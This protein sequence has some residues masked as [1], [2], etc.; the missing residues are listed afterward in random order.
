MSKI[1]ETK[2]QKPDFRTVFSLAERFQLQM[3][4]RN[5]LKG[6]ILTVDLGETLR[7]KILVTAEDMTRLEIVSTVDGIGWPEASEARGIKRL[8]IEPSELAVIEKCLRQMSGSGELTSNQLAL[9][10]RFA[11]EPKKKG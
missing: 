11:K 7:Q 8:K 3:I 5:W 6:D 1:T 4:L 9:Y 2:P 10:K